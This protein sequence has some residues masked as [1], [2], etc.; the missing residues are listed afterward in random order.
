MARTV[1]QR[2]KDE[3]WRRVEKVT[4]PM[5]K[6]EPRRRDWRESRLE[7][8]SVFV[9]YSRDDQLFYDIHP[10]HLRSWLAYERAFVVFVMGS[11]ED[12]FI[13]PALNMRCLV[14]GLVPK[15][16][17]EYKLHIVHT[18]RGYEFRERP[19]HSL[20]PFHN[21]YELLASQEQE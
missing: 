9:T 2:E 7:Y 20:S 16:H 18:E 17:G 11:H 12:V 21:S 3:V 15:G 19:G 8:L 10:D 4:G 5:W 14:E 1:S 6:V 13:V